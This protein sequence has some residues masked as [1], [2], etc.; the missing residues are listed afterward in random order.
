[1]QIQ[2][3][4]STDNGMLSLEVNENDTIQKIKESVGAQTNI[5]ATQVNLIFGGKQLQNNQTLKDYNID[6]GS[7]LHSMAKLAGGF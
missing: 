6:D 4:N 2:I 1:M 7:I 3:K 5:D